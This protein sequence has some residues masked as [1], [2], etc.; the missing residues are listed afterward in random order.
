MYVRRKAFT[1]VELLVVISIIALL[2]GLLLPAIS[3]AQRNAR[4]A[5]CATQL[6]G[7]HSALVGWA[8]NNKEQYPDAEVLDARNQTEADDVA[9]NRTGNIWSIM[10]FQR[11]ISNTEVFVSPGEVNP[12]IIPISEEAYEYRAPGVTAYGVGNVINP[13][14][15]VYDPSFKGSPLDDHLSDVDT[16][17]GPNVGNNSYAHVPLKGRYFENWSTIRQL[18]T[19][20]IVGNRGPIFQGSAPQEADEWELVTGSDA[21]FGE[22]SDTLLI[23]GGKSTWEGNVA[24]NDNH[25]KFETDPS[26]KEVTFKYINQVYRDNLFVSENYILDPEQRKDGVLKIF[27][28]GIPNDQALVDQDFDSNSEFIWYDGQTDD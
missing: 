25:V 10:L 21:R 17:M 20:P 8:Q 11:V 14:N 6:R 1:L 22:E 7:I 16:V 18:S 13:G 15:A 5:K 2:V 19:V 26:P 4:Q 27:K 9:K 12:N 28:R 3:R 24:Y 23:H